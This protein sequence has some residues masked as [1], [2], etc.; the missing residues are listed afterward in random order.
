MHTLDY[1]EKIY[2]QPKLIYVLLIK[3]SPT[4][5]L[6]CLRSWYIFY[7]RK[8]FLPEVRCDLDLYCL[9]YYKPTVTTMFSFSF[10][11][12]SPLKPVC[13]PGPLRTTER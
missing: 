6:L 8:P 5:S 9:V 12:T 3:Q 4:I 2:K 7:H 10:P 13:W 11:A 1:I